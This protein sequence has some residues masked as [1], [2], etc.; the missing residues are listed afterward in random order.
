MIFGNLWSNV[1]SPEGWLNKENKLKT[2]TYDYYIFLDYS[3]DLIGYII[4]ECGNIAGI[5]EKLE[6][7][8]HYSHVKHKNLYLAHRKK[9]I[10]LIIAEGLLLKYS[11]KKVRDSITFFLEVLEFVD[12]NGRCI[13]FAS[14]DDHHFI[15]FVRLIDNTR[16][17]PHLT[18]VKESELKKGSM[19]YKL[20]LLIDTWLNIE[21]KKS[22]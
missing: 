12:S 16:H 4:I 18:V 6:K 2:T 11:I 20:S 9:S 3:V 7:F 15:A 21:R 10:N 22:K 19:E 14:I 8:Q 13:I 17:K 1:I 5:L